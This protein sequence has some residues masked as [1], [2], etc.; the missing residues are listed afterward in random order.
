MKGWNDMWITG[1]PQ[2]HSTCLSFFSRY[3]DWER[4]LV[5]KSW[6]LSVLARQKSWQPGFGYVLSSSHM[7]GSRSQSW[8]TKQWGLA[9]A[10][11]PSGLAANI[12]SQMSCAAPQHAC[13]ATQGHKTLNPLA[14]TSNAC[15]YSPVW[16][17]K[18][19]LIWKPTFPTSLSS[20]AE[21]H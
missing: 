8:E 17:S 5:S 9:S 7:L 2:D 11:P 15:A 13:V 6:W 1:G 21:P 18:G 14:K 3:S 12:T 20:C 4:K 16:I 19:V 10:K